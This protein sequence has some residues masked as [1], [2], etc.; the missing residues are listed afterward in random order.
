MIQIELNM[1][2]GLTDTENKIFTEFTEILQC[3]RV[4]LHHDEKQGRIHG[5]YQSRTGGQGRK[6]V[7]PAFL[8]ERDGPTNRRTDGQSLL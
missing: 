5:Q 8:L 4:S 3:N 6:C 1:S 7:Y 2:L